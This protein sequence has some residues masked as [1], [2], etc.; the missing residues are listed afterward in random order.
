MREDEDDDEGGGRG[1]ARRLAKGV[2]G[3]TP[4]YLAVKVGLL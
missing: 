2:L 3:K 4:L 1:N